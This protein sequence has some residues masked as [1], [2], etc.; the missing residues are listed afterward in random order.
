MKKLIL[1]ITVL[2]SFTSFAQIEGTWN[3]AIEIPLNKIPFVIYIDKVN[4]DWNVMGGSPSET[5]KK[6]P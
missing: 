5:S 4:N 2:F 1:F 6:F 3:G